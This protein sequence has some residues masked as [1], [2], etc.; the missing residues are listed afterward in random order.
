MS[1]RSSGA[2]GIP[3][4]LVWT[5]YFYKKDIETGYYIKDKD[6]YI[7]QCFQKFI[8]RL[9]QPFMRIDQS[10]F[11]NVS[12]FDREYYTALFG[13]LVFPDGTFA[14]DYIDEFLEHEKIFMEVVSEVRSTNMFTFPVLTYSLLYQNGKFVDEEFA[15]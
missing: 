1:N 2:V 7:R 8:F 11:V 4:I 15:R 12:I 10:A 6:Y 9:N 13:D 3:N 5:F 14:I